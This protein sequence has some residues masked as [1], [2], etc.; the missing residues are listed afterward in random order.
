MAELLDWSRSALG[1]RYDLGAVDEGWFRIGGG[2][3]FGVSFQE[4]VHVLGTLTRVMIL[5]W[6]KF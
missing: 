2:V 6:V 4:S 5:L 3:D 1:R